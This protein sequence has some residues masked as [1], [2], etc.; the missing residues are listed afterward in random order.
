MTAIPQ[1]SGWAARSSDAVAD[2]LHPMTVLVRPRHR[3]DAYGAY[4]DK[5][6]TDEQWQSYWMGV[7]ADPTADLIR[8]GLYRGRWRGRSRRAKPRGSAPPS[9]TRR[10]S[11][12]GSR[13]ANPCGSTTAPPQWS[14]PKSLARPVHTTG[15]DR[16]QSGTATNDEAVRATAAIRSM[17]LGAARRP[18]SAL[19]IDEVSATRHPRTCLRMAM[20]DD[21]R[22]RP[23]WQ[24]S[25]EHARLTRWTRPESTMCSTEVP[26][27]VNGSRCSPG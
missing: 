15:D 18:R 2:R 22:R 27:A 17:T 1:S 4:A 25:F 9:R 14:M 26:M 6:A 21:A 5:T 10:R 8:S 24:M 11:G 23:P 16:R 13:R 7:M 19:R 3:P 20:C 12:R